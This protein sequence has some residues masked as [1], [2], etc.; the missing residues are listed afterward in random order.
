MTVEKCVLSSGTMTLVR[1]SKLAWGP[2]IG[3]LIVCSWE[4]GGR[5]GGHSNRWC[6]GRNGLRADRVQ[7][8]PS[9]SW[10]SCFTTEPLF[11]WNVRPLVVAGH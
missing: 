4:R 2:S 1:L 5:A 10:P 11:L 9:L 6:E 3:L 8:L 7:T